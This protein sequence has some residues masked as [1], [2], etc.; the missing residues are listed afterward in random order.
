MYFIR[1]VSIII[2]M[3]VTYVCNDSLITCS[4]I[5]GKGERIYDG[6]GP[7]VHNTRT[8]M[9]AGYCTW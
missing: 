1:Y 9:Y 5:K 4:L 6:Y 3:Y 7:T 2:K 8:Y